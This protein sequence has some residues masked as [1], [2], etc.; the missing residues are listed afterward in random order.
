MDVNFEL[1]LNNCTSRDLFKRGFKNFL[2]VT[3][4]RIILFFYDVSNYK[5]VYP[6]HD[7]NLVFEN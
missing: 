4:I 1:F 6:F 3:S 5:F 7:V 2:L